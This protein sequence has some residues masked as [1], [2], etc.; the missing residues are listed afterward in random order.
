MPLARAVSP[1]ECDDTSVTGLL[2]SIHL[3]VAVTLEDAPCDRR[4]ENLT[5]LAGAVSA[6]RRLPE[7]PAA[8]STAP[9]DVRVPE[10]HERLDV[11]LAERLVRGANGLG[12]HRLRV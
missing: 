9:V 10:G 12:S 4:R 11:G 3:Q 1:R 2:D 5:G 7:P 6:R 8:T